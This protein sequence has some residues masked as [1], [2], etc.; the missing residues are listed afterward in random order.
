MKIVFVDACY[1]IAI[2]NPKDSLRKT[3]LKAKESL[4]GKVRKITTDEILVE[5]L[6]FLSDRGYY[7]RNAA[8]KMVRAI[9]ADPNVKVLPQ[10]RNSFERG[11]KLYEE[12]M[13][14]SYSLTDCISINTMKAESMTEVLSHDKHFEQEGFHKLMV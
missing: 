8:V 6:N 11:L 12:R 13:D 5:F 1:W 4:G 9:I 3:A 10:S 2:V 14:K 7:L